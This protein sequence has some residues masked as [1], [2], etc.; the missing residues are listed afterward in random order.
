MSQLVQK[1]FN[2]RNRELIFDGKVVAYASR[3][4]KVHEHNYPT[5][6][7]ELVAMVFTLKIWRHYLYGEK[8]TIYINRKSIK[9]LLTHKELNLRLYDRVS[10]Y[11]ADVVAVALSRKSMSEQPLF[12]QLSVTSDEGLLLG[13][14]VRPTLSQQIKEKQAL[15]EQLA[16]RVR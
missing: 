11:K 6:D 12:P 7:L 10:P 15:N 16:K 14:Q 4:E 5:H 1:F 13:L 2:N 9:Y 3:K 8:C